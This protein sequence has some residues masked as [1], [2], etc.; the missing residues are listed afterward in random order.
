MLRIAYHTAGINLNR[1]RL[2]AW[3]K[4][5]AAA[6][7]DSVASPGAVVTLTPPS[8]P[9]AFEP[10]V[11][12]D[13]RRSEG[14]LLF[15]RVLYTAREGEWAFDNVPEPEVAAWRAW[16]VA[17]KG[18]RLPFVLEF[19]DLL[20][21]AVAPGPFPLAMSRPERWAG[22]MTIIEALG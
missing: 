13:D 2:L 21:V 20:V 16:Y 5:V 17:T 6:G 18:W 9:W 8:L 19:R 7:L 15:S 3:C 4:E 14:G 12:A 1:Y 22:R 11:N 10:S